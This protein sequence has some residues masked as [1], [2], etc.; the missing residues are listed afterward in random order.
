MT[1]EQ[2]KALRDIADMIVLTVKESGPIGAPGGVLYAALMTHG[3]TLHQFE[4][5]MGALVRAGK[6]TKRG[7]CY[8]AA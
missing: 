1:P 5:I 4:Q 8:F 2:V 6:L 7:H 3:C